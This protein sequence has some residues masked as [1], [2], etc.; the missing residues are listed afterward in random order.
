MD[1]CATHKIKINISTGI[2]VRLATPPVRRI[3]VP[4]SSKNI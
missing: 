4:Y 1:V 3:Y 2:A